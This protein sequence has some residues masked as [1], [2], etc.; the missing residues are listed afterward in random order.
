M[1]KKFMVIPRAEGSHGGFKPGSAMVSPTH[2]IPF[3]H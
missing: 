3:P 1:L 2:S